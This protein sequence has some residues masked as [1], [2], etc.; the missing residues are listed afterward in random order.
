[1]HIDLIYPL[2]A[3]NTISMDLPS[4][5]TSSKSPYMALAKTIIINIIINFIISVN[6]FSILFLYLLLFLLLFIC[7]HLQQTFP[8]A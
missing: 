1:M 5:N 6:F 2:I 3:N 7:L 4:D 8:I